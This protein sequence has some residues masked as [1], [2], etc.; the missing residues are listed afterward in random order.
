MTSWS[1]SR[2]R[3]MK[4][5]R[6]SCKSRQHNSHSTEDTRFKTPQTFRF[7]TSTLFTEIQTWYQIQPNYKSLVNLPKTLHLQCYSTGRLTQS[8]LKMCLSNH[9]WWKQGWFSKGST[10]NHHTGRSH[11]RDISCV[12]KHSRHDRHWASVIKGRGRLRVEDDGHWPQTAS[13]LRDALQV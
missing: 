10:I 3:R 4:C 8:E 13:L 7:F 5:Y 9:V 6:F 1:A 11:D 2:E 12:C